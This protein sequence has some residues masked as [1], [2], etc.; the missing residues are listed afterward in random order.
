MFKFVRIALALVFALALVGVEGKTKVSTK[1]KKQAAQ[2]QAAAVFIKPGSYTLQNV[3]TG[4]KLHYS[5]DRKNHIYPAKG[6]GTS[7]AISR[8]KNKKLPWHLLKIGKKNKC[9][10][11]AWG[12]SS[13][14]AAV[15]Y[16]CA[17]GKGGQKT[18]LEK[19]K[20]YWLFVPINKCTASAKPNSYQNVQLIAAQADSIET[21]NK[22]I[23]AQKAAFSK[24]GLVTDEEHA[25]MMKRL[26]RRA[27]E[28]R[29]NK[30]VS[31]GTYYVF[32][33]DHLIDLPAHAL[34][35]KTIV[36]RGI[37]NTLI[38]QWKKGDKSQQWKLI[39]H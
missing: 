1:N 26:R 36:T 21:R 9:L 28:K 6:K 8:H 7:A 14:N 23:A 27:L 22:K 5:A 11:S 18:T 25:T 20:Q 4:Q 38:K 24:R 34:T 35:G 15:M 16:V 17:S 29:A 19:T 3:K 13:N 39:K 37:K 32:T 12:S 33:S 10:S 2:L 30:T 31:S